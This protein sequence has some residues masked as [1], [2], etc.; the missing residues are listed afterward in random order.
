MPLQLILRQAL[1]F[2]LP[3]MILGFFFQVPGVIAWWVLNG[4]VVLIA[5]NQQTLFDLIFGLVTVNEPDQDIRFEVKQEPEKEELTITP[6][7][8]HIR[9]NYS[10]DGYYDV[11]ELFKQ[12]KENKLEVISITDHNCARANAAAMRF[13]SLYNIQYIPGV[14]IDAQY[15]RMRVRILGYYIDWTNEVFEIGRAHV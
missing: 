2:G 12:A 4:I 11:E 8:L 6:I 10:D 9:S 1:G 7:D 3:L 15:K 14:E 13:S 5:P